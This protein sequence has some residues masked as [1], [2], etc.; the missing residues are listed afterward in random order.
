MVN[1]FSSIGNDG[2]SRLLSCILNSFSQSYESGRSAPAI[3]RAVG[4]PLRCIIASAAADACNAAGLVQDAEED[5]DVVEMLAEAD[6]AENFVDIIAD[7]VK[8]YG[9]IEWIKASLPTNAGLPDPRR[10]ASRKLR[11]EA[12]GSFFNISLIFLCT[13]I[14]PL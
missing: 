12:S 4:N 14:I 13:F 8:G 1:Y 10:A 9:E 6:E 7:Y 5:A 11:E 3:A 2:A